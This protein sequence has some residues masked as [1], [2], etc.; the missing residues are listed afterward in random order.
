MFT[1]AGVG[2][3]TP[4]RGDDQAIHGHFFLSNHPTLV[5]TL[6]IY[7]PQAQAHLENIDILPGLKTEDSYVADPRR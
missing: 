6:R 2:R 4:D 5:E 3:R 1:L 7:L